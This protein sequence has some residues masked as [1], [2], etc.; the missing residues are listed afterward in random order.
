MR[1][2]L[3]AIVLAA[4]VASCDRAEPANVPRASKP[5]AARKQPEAPKPE[6]PRP[7][8]SAKPGETPP[9]AV[10]PDV[11]R[12]P[13]A[14][15]IELR[16]TIALDARYALGT[17]GVFI[18]DQGGGLLSTKA[19]GLIADSGGGLIATNGRNLIDRS[20]A[21]IISHHGAGL[22]S[23]VK[24]I[25]D[26]GGGF[27]SDQGGGFISDRG[28][29]RLEGAFAALSPGRVLLASGGARSEAMPV[30][31]MAVGVISLID[32][33][34][35]PLGVDGAGLA[36]YFVYTDANG[37]FEVH[38]P[39]RLAKSAVVVSCVPGT[40]DPRLAVDLVATMRARADLVVDDGT[41]VLTGYLRRAITSRLAEILDPDPCKPPPVAEEEAKSSAAA[42]ELVVET[43]RDVFD[44]S[45]LALPRPS[46]LRVLARFAEVAIA[47]TDFDVV[48]IE[49]RYG[50]RSTARGRALPAL[51]RI[52]G[53]IEAAVATRLDADPAYFDGQ[54]Y[55]AAANRDRG[56]GPPFVVR[57][58]ADLTEMLVAT[59]FTTNDLVT[60]EQAAPV[61]ADLGL[62][63]NYTEDVKAAGGSLFVAL[64]PGLVGEEVEARMRKALRAAIADEAEASPEPVP[65]CVPG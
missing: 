10:A 25:S 23:K 17:G 34:Y 53:E 46:R 45:F 37:Q 13:A 24:F 44:A 1:P 2:T 20:G 8:A 65:T 63:T 47:G 51:A 19:G 33:A 52:L 30:G 15:S 40:D 4:A 42:F 35:L 58:P 39:P 57:K 18:S 28:T 21:G 31:G 36:V 50:K 3:A 55:L 62:P 43:Y 5:P 41:T 27:I 22:T 48:D 11:L 59:Y 38:V 26:Q 6:S 12:E 54:P 32:G 29:Y 60:L 64:V 7:G 56:S 61:L 14:A 9:G 16:G 49:P